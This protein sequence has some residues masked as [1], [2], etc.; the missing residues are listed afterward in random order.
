MIIAQVSPLK[1]LSWLNMWWQ[2]G[3]SANSAILCVM[4]VCV[5]VSSASHRSVLFLLLLLMFRSWRSWAPAASCLW[6]SGIR[7]APA[8]GRGEDAL[9]DDD[10][11]GGAAVGRDVWVVAGWWLTSLRTLARVIL[12]LC[13]R[14]R[15]FWV[16]ASSSEKV[17]SASSSDRS[18]SS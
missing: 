2:N 11:C 9:G 15:P 6:S 16:T 10:T 14:L 8:E 17:G 5:R 18:S 3:S 4:C 12:T 13:E 7:N 1:F